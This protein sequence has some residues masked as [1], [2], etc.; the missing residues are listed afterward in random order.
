[1]YLVC[2]C[3]PMLYCSVGVCVVLFLS[4]LCYVPLGF[5]PSCNLPFLALLIFVE[6]YLGGDYHP[7]GDLLKKLVENL[8][9]A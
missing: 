4:R 1:M 2:A 5:A 6:I 7:P 9:H 3:F 8:E